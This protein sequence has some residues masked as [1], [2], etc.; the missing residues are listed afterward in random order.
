MTDE[1]YQK[2]LNGELS[3]EEILQI[4]EADDES[5]ASKQR[6]M[7]AEYLMSLQVLTK[8]E[9]YQVTFEYINY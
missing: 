8:N 1:L 7:L 2:I 3:D 6:V 5:L 4:N 9:A